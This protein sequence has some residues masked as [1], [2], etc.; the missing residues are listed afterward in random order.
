MRASLRYLVVWTTAT[1]LLGLGCSSAPRSASER[2]AGSSATGRFNA[3]AAV[4]TLEAAWRIVNE[5]YYDTNLHGVDWPAVLEEFRPQAARAGSLAGLRVVIQE[6]LN[7]LGQSHMALIPR[8]AAEILEETEFVPAREPDRPG[9]PRGSARRA[10][11]SLP[12]GPAQAAS[13][14]AAIEGDIGLEI[15]VLERQIVVREVAPSSPADRAG[16]RPGWVLVRIDGA[17]VEEMFVSL[18]EDSNARQE[19]LVAWASVRRKFKGPPESVVAIEFLDDRDQK[20]T[21]SIRRAPESGVPAKL[22][23]LPTFYTR[24]HSERISGLDGIQIGLI[25]FN[26]WMLPVAAAF[27]Q[28]IDELRACDGIILDLRGNPGGIGAMAMGIA[29]HFVN[30]PVVLGTMKTRETELRFIANPRRVT[31][32][33]RRVIPYAGPLA[34]LVDET[35]LSTTEI[36]AAGLQA[37]GRAAIF[38]QQTLGAALPALFDRLPNGD[39]LMHAVGDFVTPPGS[40]LEGA[41]VEPQHPVPL[42]RADL[43]SGRDRSLESASQWIARQR[44]KTGA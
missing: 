24:F 9:R 19:K 11:R 5:T 44:K 22:G 32:A 1:W 12:P 17:P 30:E 27:D 36:F 4:E 6:M 31:P 16:V 37:S 23:N 14:G 33:G 38:G 35:S 34:I 26:V 10:D 42:S 40:R 15:A 3:A 20:V 2:T 18:G 29:G 41:G 21:A 13:L 28:A 43:L 7:R 8:D 25:R 39:V